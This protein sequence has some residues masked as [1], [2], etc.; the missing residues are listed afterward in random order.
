MEVSVGRESTAGGAD[1]SLHDMVHRMTREQARAAALV[2]TVEAWLKATLQ[3]M[4]AGIQSIVG[5]GGGFL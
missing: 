3:R 1:E 4:E 2:A 5:Q